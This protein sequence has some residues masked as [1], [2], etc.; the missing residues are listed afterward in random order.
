MAQSRRFTLD[1]SG[2]DARLIEVGTGFCYVAVTP[3]L[4][5]SL[6]EGDEREL[7]LGALR[8]VVQT[9]EEHD[10]RYRV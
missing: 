5:A 9:I 2:D 7:V 3:N 1:I 4:R 8:S 10:I 6:L